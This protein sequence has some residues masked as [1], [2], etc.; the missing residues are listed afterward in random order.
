MHKYYFI[1]I[2][3]TI[4]LISCKEDNPV[5][6]DPPPT[7]SDTL[8]TIIG[9]ATDLQGIGIN[10]VLV[11]LQYNGN[12]YWDY[13]DTTGV[14][15][16]I[17]VPAGNHFVYTYKNGYKS[18]TVNVTISEG[19][20]LRN[21]DFHL[22][23]SYWYRLN[24][25]AN[26]LTA[27]DAYKNLYIN[28]QQVIFA[29][30]RNGTWVSG[31]GGFVKTSN[32]GANWETVIQNGSATEI[33]KIADNN[34]YIFTAKG[35]DSYGNYI[36]ENKLYRSNDF[37]GSWQELLNF[38]LDQINGHKIA[39]MNNGTLFLNIHGVQYP[40]INQIF[41]FYKSVNQGASW[42]NY[43]PVNQYNVR[44]INKSSSGKIYIAN[45][46]DSMYYSTNGSNWTLKIVNNSTIRNNL[47]NSVV[48][49]TS[50]MIVSGSTNYN[51][52]YDDGESWNPLNTNLSSFPKSDKFS[53]NTNNEIF[54]I[55]N[56][57]SNNR[58]GVYKSTDKCQ[59]WILIDDG[60]PQMYQPVSLTIFQ[61]Y[62]YL[63]LEDGYLYRTSKNTT[64]TIFDNI[65]VL[66]RNRNFQ[67]LR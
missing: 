34:L 4:L 19:D 49:P 53:Y 42:D 56:D 67:K 65:N 15:T 28:P 66:N 24:A 43:S 36:G 25:S 13:S 27:A 52:S 48:L 51:I 37:G 12:Y 39:A 26:Y 31:Q 7:P 23:Q 18:D 9:K 45:Y 20:T 40:N 46:S 14:Y 57:E 41:N 11:K 33:Y 16:I 61:D 21:V 47:I 63:L 62:G 44:G 10:N 17:R 50:E 32:F 5:V 6:I 58:F 35:Q 30:T 54:G 2:F 38:N 64:E 3:I 1:L 22:Q 8:G 60:L 55:V 29:S 59:T